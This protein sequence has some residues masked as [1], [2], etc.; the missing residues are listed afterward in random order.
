MA[1]VCA[2][3][4]LTS[5]GFADG[6]AAPHRHPRASPSAETPEGGPSAELQ[7]TPSR[8]RRPSAH[9]NRTN[10]NA[11]NAADGLLCPPIIICSLSIT[12]S[13]KKTAYHVFDDRKKTQHL[14][15]PTQKSMDSTIVP[16]LSGLFRKRSMKWFTSR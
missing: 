9:T 10:Q 13:F 12:S 15:P 11:K 7:A 16:C 2:L 14:P 5:G 6:A 3:R 8:G 1:V 4:V